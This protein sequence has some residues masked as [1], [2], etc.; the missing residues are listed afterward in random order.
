MAQTSPT[1]TKQTPPPPTAPPK[2]EFPGHATRKLSNGLT[3][4]IVEDHR[5]PLV[6]MSLDILAGSAKDEPSKAGVATMT[7]ALLREGTATRS[8]EELSRLIDDCGGALNASSDE[9]TTTVSGSFMKSFTDLGLELMADIVLRP[10]FDQEEIDRQMQQA[11]SGM[12]MQYSDVA[13]LANLVGGRVIFDKHPYGYPNEGTPQTLRRIKREDLVNFHKTYYSPASSFLAI[14]GDIS[15]DEAV[16]KAEKFFGSWKTPVPA[17]SR[18][19]AAPATKRRV[20]VVDVPSA[21]QTQIYVGQVT[22]PRNHPD[23]VPLNIANQVF[24]GSFNSRLNL[25]LRANEGLTYGA[26]SMMQPLRESGAWGVKTFTRTEKTADA[27]KMILDLLNEWRVNPATDA[28]FEEARRF[29]MGAFGLSVETSGAVA[30]RVVT[31]AVYG[32]PDGYWTNYRQLLESQTR[33]HV[34]AVVQKNIKPDS[35]AI[36]AVGDAKAFAKSLE[37]FGTVTV[38]PADDL[39]VI[40]PDLHKPKEIQS[41]SAEGDAK[42]KAIMD[43]AIEASGGLAALQKIKDLSSK[44]NMTMSTPQG[45]IPAAAAEDVLYPNRYRITMKLPIGEVTQAFDGQ[46]GWI[47]QGATVRDV[48]PEM[49]KE[50][51]KGAIVASGVGLLVTAGEGKVELHLIPPIELD[52]KSLDGVL[53]KRGAEEIK[54]YFDPETKL[55]AKVTYETVGASGPVETDSVFS[56]YRETGGVKLPFKEVIHQNGIK[57]GERVI[58]ERKINGGLQPALFQKP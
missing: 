39:D 47:A 43:S 50:F 18:L 13:Y 1:S 22:V 41:H 4:F 12:Q 20:V 27:I 2:F 11:Q 54:T 10:K 23:Y 37:T 21:V 51:A 42:A 14:A 32:L 35:V 57:V 8:S 34:A 24:G 46:S 25:K 40:A 52:G 36:I 3:L 5:L 45:E 15:A 29:M 58:T 30:G 16:A 48:P 44:G 38:I 19:P 56:D 28:E 9:D 17:S 53:W 49:G 31:A 33:E 6:S 55:L 7:A 26:S